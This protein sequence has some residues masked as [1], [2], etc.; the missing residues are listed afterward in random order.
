MGEPA[1][2]IGLETVLMKAYYLSQG[3]IAQDLRKV[4][5]DYFVNLDY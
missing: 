5:Q 3:E 1:V 2:Q 4:M